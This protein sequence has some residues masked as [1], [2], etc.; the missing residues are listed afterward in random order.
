[1]RVLYCDCSIEIDDATLDNTPAMLLPMQEAFMFPAQLFLALSGPGGVPI[2]GANPVAQSSV[3]LEATSRPT[4]SDV[5][6][7]ADYSLPTKAA[8][9]DPGV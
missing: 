1:M 8:G 6:T 3:N 2:P 9:R 5:T 7:S 4:S